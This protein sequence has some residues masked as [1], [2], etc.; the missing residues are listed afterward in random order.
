VVL[1]GKLRFHDEE[2]DGY[3][4]EDFLMAFVRCCQLVMQENLNITDPSTLCCCVLESSQ[5]WNEGEAHVTHFR[6]QFPYCRTEL[7]VQTRLLRPRLIQLLRTTNVMGHLHQQPIGDWEQ[8]IDPTIPQETL[9]M[10]GSTMAP[11]EAKMQ[12]N[13]LWPVITEQHLKERSIDSLELDHFFNMVQYHQHV[14]QGLIRTS[15]FHDAP[16]TNHWLPLFLSTYF[17]LGLTTER[18]RDDIQTIGRTTFTLGTP[19]V[20]TNAGM[21]SIENESDLGIAE[22]LL[23]LL[24]TDRV[25]GENYWL[26][27]GRAL[28][29]ADNGGEA[30]LHHWIQFTERSDS[31]SAEDCRNLYYGFTPNGITI[32]TIGWYASKDSPDSYRAWHLK[33]C[34]A[35]M[36]RAS[37][38]L[39][40]DVAEALYRVYWLDYVCSSVSQSIWYKFREN[41]YV[42]L[43]S[44]VELSRALSTDFLRRFESLRLSI[45]QRGME[46][47]DNEQKDKYEMLNKKLSTLI[48][49][50]KTV[51]YKSNVMKEAREKFYHERFNDFLDKNENLLGMYN[52]VLEACE[53]KIIARGGKPEDYVS[54][55]TG[56]P[57]RAEYSWETPVVKMLMKWLHQVFV[58][59]EL[60]HYTMKDFASFLKGKNSEKLFRIWTG[61][62]NN[63][64]SMI[65]KLFEAA[66]GSYVV[67]IPVEL[68]TSKKQGSGSASPELAQTKGTRAAFMEEPD[69]DEPM[70]KGVI[71]RYTG[72]DSLFMRFLH[73]NGGK[74]EAMMKLILISND[75]PAIP[76]SDSATKERVL[77]SPFFSRWLKPNDPNLP[78]TEEEQMEKRLFKQDRFFEKKI[79][80]MA[81]AFIWVLS[82]YYPAYINEGLADTPK[83]VREETK[84]YWDK[85][86]YYQMYV[87]DCLEAAFLP[88]GTT[89]DHN[90]TLTFTE[91]SNAFKIWFRDMYPGVVVPKGEVIKSEFARILGPQQNRKW[92]GV[93]IREE[94][95]QATAGNILKSR[96]L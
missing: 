27:V 66:F 9:P 67:K 23:P 91:L 59:P 76:G 75:V 35:A 21:S 26:D 15:V 89:P 62:G 58:D 42:K 13:Y 11:Q 77:I 52:C 46:A 2:E 56:V 3:Y 43:D 20:A 61:M 55:S 7:S 17:W 81:S 70:K 41:R 44:G 32:K 87:N 53:D 36:E 25:D 73:E 86:D 88:D 48:C 24:S 69:D 50:L 19:R 10:Y 51:S 12:L 4:H 14:Q 92:R 37:S 72:G 63:S 39:H 1:Y 64:K 22:R 18:V 93:R 94:E 78:A 30:G 38:G 54:M 40:T 49:K 6:V 65:V 74:V 16:D 31:K 96:D 79:P 29:N 84:K 57:Y 28:Y 68:V 71:K 45:L 82:Q 83:A 85:H 47:T 90:S 80:E 33:W 5:S 34:Q 60:F 8:I 95:Q